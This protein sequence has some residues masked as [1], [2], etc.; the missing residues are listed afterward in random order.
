MAPLREQSAIQARLA[1]KAER[2]DVGRTDQYRNKPVQ[3]RGSRKLDFEM[4]ESSN[5]PAFNALDNVYN[6]KARPKRAWTLKQETQADRVIE[7]GSD[8]VDN[9]FASDTPAGA[10]SRKR[11]GQE[12]FAQELQDPDFK[13]PLVKP[14]RRDMDQ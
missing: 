7:E 9:S 4:A 12:G 8:D 10:L 5:V 14:N 1:S 6:V 13:S 3:K 2:G 11:R